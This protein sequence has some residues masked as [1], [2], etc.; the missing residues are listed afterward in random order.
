MPRVKPQ[1]SM[2]ECAALAGEWLPDGQPNTLLMRRRFHKH[3]DDILFKMPGM[4]LKWYV[5]REA[6]R[7]FYAPYYE[8]ALRDSRYWEEGCDHPPTDIEHKRAGL[9]WCHACGAIR[10]M[11]LPWELP[12][13]AQDD[14]Q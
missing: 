1:L 3:P 14:L 13:S 7:E 6:L 8:E 10:D 4:D 2:R 12:L 11:G 5:S 9:R